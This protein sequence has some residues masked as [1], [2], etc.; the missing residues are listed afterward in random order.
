MQRSYITG[1]KSDNIKCQKKDFNPVC[2]TS[3]PL[4]TIRDFYSV[5][6]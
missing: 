5:N 1:A 4:T 6:R 2:L 3:G